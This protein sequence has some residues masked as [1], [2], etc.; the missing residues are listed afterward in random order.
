MRSIS[1]A[2]SSPANLVLLLVSVWLGISPSL[3]IGQEPDCQYQTG[4]PTV[5][6]ARRVFRSADLVC[7]EM[8]LRELLDNDQVPGKT[9][10]D[11]HLLLASIYFV[12]DVDESLRRGKVKQELVAL[13][14]ADRYWQGELE[15][16]TSEFRKIL[17][18]ARGLA[19]WRYRNSPELQKKYEQQLL[20]DTSLTASQTDSSWQPNQTKKNW[21][22]RW[23]AV[24]SGVGIIAMAAI[25][26][27]GSNNSPEPILVDT[28]PP[29]PDAP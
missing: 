3:L 25:L 29:F 18:D 24:G 14:L 11:A 5:A 10:A 6:N 16:R 17:A 23:W 12:E 9:K 4:H 26:M 13:Y 22:T 15:I 27:S 21:Y 1:Q 28:L 19:D 20:L 8:E 7:A 2:Y